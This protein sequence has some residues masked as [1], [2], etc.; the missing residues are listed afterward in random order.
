MRLYKF[1]R[2]HEQT[3]KKK[4]RL[5][6]WKLGGLTPRQLLKRV[7]HE[8]D[9]D[10]VFTR[11]AALA[12]YFVS[13]LVPMVFFLMAILGLLAQGHDLQSGL[14]GYAGRFMPPDAYTLLQKTLK[15]ITNNS[16]GL[17]LA[18]GLVLALWSGSGGVSSIMDA[19]NRCYH[20]KDSRPFWKQRL[21]AVALTV[22]ISALTISAL[23]IILYGGTIVQF[24]GA[25]TGLSSATVMAWRIVQWPVALFF[26]ILAFALLYFWGPDAEQEWQWITP[27]SL[28]GV[29]L[30]IGVSLIFR[31]YLHYFNSYSKTYGSLGAV[32]I[33][34]Y[35]LYFSSIALL[36]GGEINSEI[37][38]AA[39]KRGHPEAKEA[40]EKVA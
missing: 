25:H 19:L 24:V 3:E 29:L 7:Y 14:L 21:I 30:W 32:I 5:S 38:N 37:E 33:L 23:V 18:L 13:A 26:V 36:A 35:W 1:E 20:V 31:A 16:T 28:V 10:E 9:E 15:E 4:E 40:G 22:A 17:K 6:P 39:A 27:G 11:S 34:L 12:F 8:F 2:S